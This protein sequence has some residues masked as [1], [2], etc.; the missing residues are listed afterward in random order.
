MVDSRLR[1][2]PPSIFHCFARVVAPQQG[3]ASYVER[4]Y[5]GNFEEKESILKGLPAFCFPCSINYDGVQYST[6]VLTDLESNFRYGFCRYPPRADHCLCVVSYLP[7]FPTFYGVLDKVAQLDPK[8]NYNGVE[9]FLETLNEQ[10]IPTPGSKLYFHFNHDGETQSFKIGIPDTTKLPS[11]PD[12]RNLTEYFAKVTPE[13][14]VYLF[15]SMLFERRI[16]ICSEKLSLLTAVIHG[17]VSLLYPMQWQHIFIPILPTHLIDYC[18]APMPFLL[19][20]HASMM[21]KVRMMPL[22]EVVIFDADT[23]EIIM[24]EEDL[25]VFP[26]KLTSKLKRKLRHLERASGDY[27]SRQFLNALADIMGGYRD[28]LKFMEKDDGEKIVFDDDMFVNSRT[29]STRIYLESILSLQSFRQFIAGRLEKLN[30]DQALEDMFER[31]INQRSLDAANERNPHI[32]EKMRK[33]RRVIKTGGVALKKTVD[34]SYSHLKEMAHD[35]DT[36]ELKKKIKDKVKDVKDNIIQKGHKDS[37]GE[38]KPRPER[39]SWSPVVKRVQSNANNEQVQVRDKDGTF[40]NEPSSQVL[41]R[42]RPPQRPPRPTSELFSKHRALTAPPGTVSTDSSMNDIPTL[43][44]ISGGVDVEDNVSATLSFATT[45]GSESSLEDS[46]DS[47]EN[48]YLDT[49]EHNLVTPDG[50]ISLKSDSPTEEDLIFEQS[51]ISYNHQHSPATMTS[52]QNPV[53]KKFEDD[54]LFY[55][56]KVSLNDYSETEDPREHVTSP[57]TLTRQR[58]VMGKKP[59]VPPRP[60]RQGSLVGERPQIPT[61]PEMLRSPSHD[62][63]VSVARGMVYSDKTHGDERNDL[64]QL[65]SNQ[66]TAYGVPTYVTSSSESRSSPT[67]LPSADLLGLEQSLFHETMKA[68]SDDTR[69]MLDDTRSLSLSN[70]SAAHGNGNATYGQPINYGNQMGFNQQRGY[71]QK[72]NN[73][74]YGNHYQGNNYGNYQGNGLTTNRIVNNRTFYEKIEKPSNPFTSTGGRV[75]SPSNPFKSSAG[76]VVDP[77]VVNSTSTHDAFANVLEEAK[78]MKYIPR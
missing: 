23:N 1:L 30:D 48:L 2:N 7:W 37:Y 22:S 10:T 19:G 18:C 67:A 64:I 34:G 47:H 26:A 44:N 36:K 6:F 49:N 45:S 76:R 42:R 24:L 21:E 8:N 46:E 29:G 14:M 32:K 50:L 75:V 53:M 4:T 59:M 3:E 5:P 68:M 13:N 11:I 12:D 20:V 71:E 15:I 65:K 33:G 9:Q 77:K 73:G 54:Q 52:Y 55:K 43:L 39:K 69:S 51:S 17:A 63:G 27:V 60:H 62:S 35:I 56:P 31:A 16:I 40:T 38:I 78:N 72:S 41:P 25:T 61:R 66:Q 74:N 70:A 57:T 58:Y 28:A